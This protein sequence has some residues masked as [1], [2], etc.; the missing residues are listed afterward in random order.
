MTIDDDLQGAVQALSR[1]KP[2]KPFERFIAHIRFPRFKNLNPGA[3]IDFG[4]P[5]TALV[6]GN[7]CGKTS[8]I[9]ALYGAPERSSTSDYWFATSVD[10]I[11]SREHDPQRFI[12]GHWL[13]HPTWHP[14]G[15]IVETRKARV[16]KA[17]DPEY[18]EPTKVTSGDGMEAMPD[19]GPNTQFGGPKERVRSLD[20]WSAVKRD[21]LY[22][23]FRCEL[24]AFDQFFWFGQLPRRATHT[25]QDEIRAKSSLLKRVLDEDLQTLS[26]HAKERVFKS[27]N[28]AEDDLNAAREILGKRYASARLIEHNLYG[29]QR[30]RTVVFTAEDVSYSEAFAGSGEMAVVSL[31]VQVRAQKK[32]TLILLDEPE[33][34]LHPAAQKRLLHFLLEECRKK[35]HQVVFTTHSPHLVENL[36]PAAI[37]V[38]VPDATGRFDVLNE[39]HPYA[40]FHRLGATSPKRVKVL[41]EDRLAKH[42]VDL[43]SSLLT[44]DDRA[45][46]DV[47]FLPGGADTYFTHRIP[48]LM[49]EKNVWLLLDGDQKRAESK[50]SSDI[51][52]NKV[53]ETITALVG[54]RKI[55][56]GA[57]G[58][59]DADS[60]KRLSDEKRRYID[61][62]H[63]RVRFLPRS[64][65]EEIVLKALDSN[66][67]P[68]SSDEAKTQLRNKLEG[69]GL[70]PSSSDSDAQAQLLLAQN[71]TGNQDLKEVAA[72][73]KSMLASASSGGTK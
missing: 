24:G 36:P 50:P 21:V 23:N 59:A 4:F 72:L 26:W 64:C 40:A 44:E 35:H 55:V 73:L 43:A 14:T 25:K 49:R 27:H 7:G 54:G 67:A 41:V 12:Y 63:E 2:G 46:F 32:E 5:V 28:L 11:V 6:G 48:T 65:P 70:T 37:K 58:G 47:D 60:A 29:G 1:M 20:R 69:F 16:K 51:A 33:V 66:A 30:A 71:Q 15:G 8:V 42:V 22:L 9:H 52:D 10:E 57:D 61:Y 45:T 17:D 62:M 3:R 31:V 53:D 13:K 34:S 68:R 56:Y 19:V 39:V 38:F 18:W